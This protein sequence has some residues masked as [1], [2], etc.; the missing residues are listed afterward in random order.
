MHHSNWYSYLPEEKRCWLYPLSLL[1]LCTVPRATYPEHP[2]H[3]LARGVL[4]LANAAEPWHPLRTFDGGCAASMID[5]R[6]FSFLRCPL[7]CEGSI[8]P[9]PRIG[10]APHRLRQRR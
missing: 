9:P 2:E 5:A 3:T 6:A 8:V 1:E 7:K 10:R 4:A